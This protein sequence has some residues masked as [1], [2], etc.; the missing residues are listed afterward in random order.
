VVMLVVFDLLGLGNGVAKQWLALINDRVH[1][2][3][4][5]TIGMLVISQYKTCV[6]RD[7]NF[8]CTARKSPNE[9]SAYV[10][11]RGSVICQ[12]QTG[13]SRPASAEKVPFLGHIFRRD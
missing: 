6:L 2:E 3:H 1:P 12:L 9:S 4:N 10:I 5:K 11:G 7:Q 13:S 8:C